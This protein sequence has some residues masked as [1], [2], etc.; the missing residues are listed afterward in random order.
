MFFIVK[1]MEFVRVLEETSNTECLNLELAFRQSAMENIEYTTWEL[2]GRSPDQ[3]LEARISQK[4][5]WKRC[6]LVVS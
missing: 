6:Q 1:T 4:K 2:V 5:P 3:K